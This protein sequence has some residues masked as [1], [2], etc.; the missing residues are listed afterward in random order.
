ML[1]ILALAV[2]CVA[3]TD[4]PEF[5]ERIHEACEYPG[6]AAVVK[7]FELMGN[8][9]RLRVTMTRQAT[10]TGRVI[11]GTQFASDMRHMAREVWRSIR[12][13]YP[14][15]RFEYVFKDGNGVSLCGFAFVPDEANKLDLP[16]SAQCLAEVQ[17][18]EV[19]AYREWWQ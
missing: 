9:E 16:V 15:E 11:A 17:R 10:E 18:P 2:G 14:T 5:K 1:M 12:W 3:T 8:H 19:G 7:S 4:V 6:T 13:G